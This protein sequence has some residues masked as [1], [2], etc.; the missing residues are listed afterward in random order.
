MP[1]E[2]R[3]SDPALATLIEGV[4]VTERGLEQT[5]KKFGVRPVEA[6]GQKFDPGFHQA[7]YEV[8]NSEL[9]AGT[10]VE[11]IQP[12]YASAT[13]CSARRW[14]RSPRAAR[15]RPGRQRRPQDRADRH[16]A[17]LSE[18]PRRRS[19]RGLELGRVAARRPARSS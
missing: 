4:E 16:P 15:R 7:M 19:E 17:R 13:A 18:E 6:T 14:W 1:A 10:V 8:A 5:L 3:A 9:P 2:A 11:V 12:G